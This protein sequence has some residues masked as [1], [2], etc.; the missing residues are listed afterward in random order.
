MLCSWIPDSCLVRESQILHDCWDK[1]IQILHDR[2]W[3]Q[4]LRDHDLWRFS[5]HIIFPSLLSSS[6]LNIRFFKND[7]AV[8][9]VS[10]DWLAVALVAVH[11]QY[12]SKLCV[13]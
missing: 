4:N 12:L 3:C 10:A 8:P 1:G 2:S 11:Q 9:S 13:G 6:G 7:K 5:S